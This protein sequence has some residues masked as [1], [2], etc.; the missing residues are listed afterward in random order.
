MEPAVIAAPIRKTHVSVELHPAGYGVAVGVA[1][2]VGASEVAANTVAVGFG[3]G[4]S[5]A[6]GTTVMVGL[7]ESVSVSVAVGIGVGVDGMTPSGRLFFSILHS[8]YVS[9]PEIHPVYQADG[10]LPESGTRTLI[11][12]TPGLY[13]SLKNAPSLRAVGIR[14]VLGGTGTTPG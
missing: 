5:V 11:H 14:L 9:L 6:V 3:V 1:W 13:P 4:V 7:G 10:A 8:T 2:A 12:K